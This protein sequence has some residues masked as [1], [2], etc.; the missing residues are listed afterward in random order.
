MAVKLGDFPRV[1]TFIPNN[2]SFTLSGCYGQL[3]VRSH[4]SAELQE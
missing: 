1:L 2:I 3:S 4:F